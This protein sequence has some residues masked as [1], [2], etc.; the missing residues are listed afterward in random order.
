MSIIIESTESYDLLSG[1]GDKSAFPAMNTASV[2][3]FVTEFRLETYMMPETVDT[4]S[5]EIFIFVEPLSTFTG[6]VRDD[7]AI[8]T[9]ESAGFN[10]N[11]WHVGDTWVID[12]MTIPANNATGTI[13]EISA[14]RQTIIT[15]YNFT[16]PEVLPVDGYLANTTP[17]SSMEYMFN[18]I[19]NE[20]SPTFVSPIDGE[21]QRAITANL[22]YSDTSTGHVMVMQGKKSWQFG[23]ITVYGNG[24]GQGNP[25]LISGVIQAFKVVHEVLISPLVLVGEWSDVTARIAPERLAGINSFKYINSIGLS[26]NANNPND[27]TVVE[28]LDV[29]GSTGWFE[30]NLNGGPKKYSVENVLYKRL[31]NTL[32]ESLQLTTVETKVQFDLVNTENA[33]FSDNNTKFIVGFNYAPADEAQY[34]G[35]ALANAQTQEYNFIYDNVLTTLGQ[36]SG[37]PRQDGTDLSVIKSLTVTYDSTSRVNVEVIIEMSS[38]VVSRISANPTQ[39]FMLYI[40]ASDH[41]LT[42]ANSDKEQTFIDTNVFYVDNSD[43]TMFAMDQQFLEHPSSDLDTEGVAFPDARIVDDLLGFNNI[44]FDKATRE[45]DDIIF[46]GISG[47]I[48]AKK[49]TGA[50]FILDS[51]SFGLSNLKIVT[52]AVYGGVPNPEIEADRGF[53]TPADSNRAN[54]KF[55]RRYAADSGAIKEYRFQYP[56]IIR[57]EDF[58]Y[59]PTASDD[60]FDPTEPNDGLN[61]D[62]VRIDAFSDWNIYFKT[63]LSVTKNGNPLTYEQESRIWTYDYDLGPEWSGNVLRTYDENDNLLTS[64]GSP[65][66]IKYADGRIEAEFNF[67]GATTPSISDLVIV[68]KI[69]V[70]E[71]GTFKGTYW[72]SSAYDASPS[73]W[74]YS[75]D[76]SN[77]VVITNPSLNKFIG[78]AKLSGAKLPK[79]PQFKIT[80]RIYDIRAAEPPGPPD[81]PKLMEDGTPKIMDGSNDFKLME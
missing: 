60:M 69:D 53:K 74:W 45:T 63:S 79:K 19:D 35:N 33:P 75:V 7:R 41:T 73:T 4:S 43:P 27:M 47:Q 5:S 56:F 52:D 71:E 50:A 25:A 54:I 59:L 15:D 32:N 42:R 81:V 8:Y 51:R 44:S 68:L 76:T 72:I 78:E 66:V 38:A 2:Q 6:K 17:V 14:D 36:A 40:E 20:S 11:D 1:V 70:Y 12:G 49:S 10:E 77:R 21:T 39:R 9:N 58:V 23:T 67:I 61:Q 57:W 65:I 28:V 13:L 22:D 46:T 55:F 48:I 26:I 18:L 24:T 62:W 30:E 31:D 64:G 80:P 16:V 37:T 3:T 34:R 29:D